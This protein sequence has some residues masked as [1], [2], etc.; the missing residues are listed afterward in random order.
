MNKRFLILLTFCVFNVYANQNYLL[1]QGDV[2]V[3]QHDLD[4]FSFTI[5]QKDRFGFFQSQSRINNTLLVLLNMKHIA[6]YG[7][8]NIE[9]DKLEELYQKNIAELY[10]SFQAKNIVEETNTLIVKDYIKLRAINDLVKRNLVNNVKANSSIEEVAKEEYLAN[11]DN[12]K[13]VKEIN[14]SYITI[15]FNPDNKT[16]KVKLAN[17]IIVDILKSKDEFKNIISNY[18]KDDNIEMAGTIKDNKFIAKDFFS[19]QIFSNGVGLIQKPI[20][21]NSRLFIIRVD[22]IKPEAFKDFDS[23]KGD[24]MSSIM[25]SIISEKYGD[26]IVE[27]TQN[28]KLEINKIGIENIRNLYK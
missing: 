22:K 16:E 5:P 9:S 12:Y 26:L 8:N 27:L 10:K 28:K 3:T 25:N 7:L 11:K 20:I 4:G 19:E 18:N 21:E 6:K 17:K 2:T 24:L 1:K 14:Y 23:I 13:T 15:L